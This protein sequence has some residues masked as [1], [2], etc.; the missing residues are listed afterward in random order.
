[1]L[2]AG[3]LQVIR[4]SESLA[5]R[6]LRELWGGG[7]YWRND[8]YTVF[9]YAPVKGL[10]Y[11][12]GVSR[13]DP[14]TIIKVGDTFY[15]WY[16]RTPKGLKPVGFD[17]VTE[18]LPATTWDMASIYY[19]T[20]K[21]GW[22]W[23]EQGPA[24]VPGPKG[25]YDDRSVFTP[26]VLVAPLLRF[27]KQNGGVKYYLYYQATSGVYRRRTINVMGMSWADSPDGPWHR[28]KEP[29]LRPD[30]SGQWLGD[31]DDRGKVKEYG[32]WDS[33]KVH[34]PCLIIRNGKYWL[35]YK[36][37][38]KGRGHHSDL[39]IAWGVA[40][41]DR[42]EGPF[43]KSP[44]NP[45]TN[46]GHE[47]LV[48]PYREGVAALITTDG[49]EKNTIQYAPDGLNF[50]IKSH[51]AI[52]PD[53]AGVYCPDAYTN[54]TDGKGFTWGLC[55]VEQREEDNPWP[56]L[57]RFECDLSREVERK[58]VFKAQNHRFS[59]KAFFSGKNK[60]RPEDL[61]QDR[62]AGSNNK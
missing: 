1:M 17:K 37:A 31:V 53:A 52:P 19:A 60:L 14:S 11:E 43:I 10:G 50:E 47:V 25:N 36:G 18:H 27:A 32:A 16:T 6:R 2:P 22:T 23:Q 26:N 30:D 20:S 61:K 34:D 38:P 51:V 5:T 35:Y 24:V 54:T 29:V 9:K 4:S 59:D 39:G 28:A 62:I 15:V 49:Y 42:P 58:W 7:G 55:H 21:D 41:A 44:L 13:R 56:Y 3:C 45:I 12:E 8:F 33:H 57:I 40:I 46:S 48:W